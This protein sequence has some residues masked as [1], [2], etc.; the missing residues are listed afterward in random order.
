M[1]HRE[2]GGGVNFATMVGQRCPHCQHVLPATLYEAAG[3]AICPECDQTLHWHDGTLRTMSNAELQQLDDD[4]RRTIENAAAGMIIGM[5]LSDGEDFTVE[6]WLDD[7]G[8]LIDA[9][10]LR[11]KH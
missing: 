9:R 4:V 5:D 3:I 10:T 1:P 11:S 8:N 2:S 6:A 7:D